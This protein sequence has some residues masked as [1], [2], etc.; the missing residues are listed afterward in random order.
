MER[1]S[2]TTGAADPNAAPRLANDARSLA[3]GFLKELSKGLEMLLSKQI[4]KVEVI[5]FDTF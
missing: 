3:G 2:Y 1:V 5:M 4:W